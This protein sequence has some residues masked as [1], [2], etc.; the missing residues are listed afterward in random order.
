MAARTLPMGAGSFTLTGQAA[1]LVYTKVAE[2]GT[3][4]LDGQN[5]GLVYQRTALAAEAGEFLLDGQDAGLSQ[6]RRIDV[7][8]F[9]LDGQNAGLYAARQLVVDAGSYS[10][11]GQDTI[12]R[13]LHA[14]VGTF[15]LTGKPAIILHV[16]PALAAG[17]GSYT[18]TGQAASLKQQRKLQTVVGSFS[19]S[20]LQAGLRYGHPF[21]PEAASFTLTGV[22]AT[23]SR[24]RRLTGSAGTFT[25]SGNPA[26]GG[27]SGAPFGTGSFLLSGQA[28]GLVFGRVP[29]TASVGAYT[30]TGKA[31][32]L[33][34]AGR[35]LVGSY[36]LTGQSAALRQARYL[37]A[38]PIESPTL[39]GWTLF[40]PL[41]CVALGQID[42][43][44]R[45]TFQL[46]GQEAALAQ[47]KALVPEAGAYVY[48]GRSTHGIK[49]RPIIARP[50]DGQG[51]R[52][53]SQGGSRPTRPTTATSA[54]VRASSGSGQPIKATAT[55]S[56]ARARSLS[57]VD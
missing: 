39:V 45:T 24:T 12:V 53:R 29:L 13:V 4:L 28:A 32:Q 46:S 16:F 43:F 34:K 5:A 2:P 37:Y 48:T 44:P 20:G 40:A 22:S 51:F 19:F 21:F 31:A 55:S 42:E 57:P 25:L 47:G 23:L 36:T 9:L 14:D 38:S 26:V 50:I 11:T 18:L 6:Q 49:N 7:G 41:G 35:L 15:T 1:G 27:R 10:L 17:A 3:F 30:L 33:F 52:P 8:T 54:S 56:G